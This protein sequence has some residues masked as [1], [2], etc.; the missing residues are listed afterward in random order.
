LAAARR[1][2]ATAGF[3]FG[4]AALNIRAGVARIGSILE[5]MNGQHLDQLPVI[6]RRAWRASA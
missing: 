5:A 6:G 2:S 1:F 4:V 3:D